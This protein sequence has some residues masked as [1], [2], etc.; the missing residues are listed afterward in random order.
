MP[1]DYDITVDL[2]T[3][4]VAFAGAPTETW[5]VTLVDT[6][7]ATMTG[8]RLRRVASHIGNDTFCLTYGDDVA[9]LDIRDVIAHHKK[10][11]RKA[12]ITA[13]PSPGRFGILEMGTDGSVESF[14]EKPTNEMGWINGGFFVLKPDFIADIE[15]DATIWERTPLERLA[16][17]GQ[18]SAYKHSGFWRPMDTLRD[19][20][21]LEELWASGKAPWERW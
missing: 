17:E 14:R 3:N 21:E 16:A 13:V 18:P 2:A 4:S 19:K 10:H 15:G 12:T 11:K 9:D 7:V 8:G 20:R 1:K 6:G 5:K